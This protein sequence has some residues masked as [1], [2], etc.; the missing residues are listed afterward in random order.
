M[1][2]QPV[3]SK[4]TT[5]AGTTTYGAVNANGTQVQT[6]T[7]TSK[8]SSGQTVAQMTASAPAAAPVTTPVTSNPA[9]SFVAPL[10]QNT[11]AP[12]AP[13]STAVQGGTG[14]ATTPVAQKYGGQPIPAGMTQA[15]YLQSLGAYENYINPDEQ[16]RID[17]AGNEAGQPV[18][19]KIEDAEL[20]KGGAVGGMGGTYSSAIA[21]SYDKQIVSLQT[22]KVN[23]INQAKIAMETAIK[24]GKQ[25]DYDK[26]MGYYNTAIQNDQAQQTLNNTKASTDASIAKT[27]ADT[28]AQTFQNVVSNVAPDIDARL[29]NGEDVSTILADYTAKGYDPTVLNA[30]LVTY[31]QAKQKQDLLNGAQTATILSKTSLGKSVNIPGIGDVTVLGVN[32]T[33]APT[34]LDAGNAGLQEYTPDPTTGVMGWHAIVDP[35]TKQPLTSDAALKLLVSAV[36]N[37]NAD[38]SQLKSIFAGVSGSPLGGISGSFSEAPAGGFRTDRSNNPIAAA[39]ATGGTNDYTKA[40][41]AAGIKW[42]YGDKFA[43]NPNMQTIKIDNSKDAVE[44]SRAILSNSSSIQ[45]WY[46]NHTGKSILT[47][48]GISNN[49]DFKKADKKTQDTVITEIYKNEGGDGSLV[50]QSPTLNTPQTIAQAIMEGKQA[51]ILTG[52]YGQSANVRAALQKKGYDLASAQM[53]WQATQKLLTTMNSSQQ[54]RLRQAV[55]FSYDS[56]DIIDQLNQAWKGGNF[57]LFNSAAITAA[58]S[59]VDNKPLAKPIDITIPNPD[60]SSTT[61]T[62]KDKQGLATL[63]NAQINDLTSELG[64]VYKGGNTS[65]DESLSLA[66]G[67]LKSNWSEETLNSAVQLAR[68]NLQLRKNSIETTQPWTPNGNNNIYTNGSSKFSPDQITTAKKSLQDGEILVMDNTSGQMGA[69]SQDDF[70]PDAY[71]IIQ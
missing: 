68:T 19:Q 12:N 13:V 40:L 6:F 8:N 66:A 7:P 60:G 26:A 52:L 50:G 15:Q 42:S 49:E 20:A 27:Q 54:T 61:T 46:A 41:D 23:A 36:L 14:G 21:A 51:P 57:P 33:G 18:E 38:L 39:V 43:D 63:L 24:T 11:G 29:A 5:A 34:T 3:G 59:G 44:A 69:I 58:S 4:V 2:T 32:N 30:A 48:L 31:Q 53:D 25:A 64:T 70:D 16:A 9:G 47:Q 67:N 17:E 62:I 10:K 1:A 65:T 71:T 22:Q 56:L 28:A 35:N 45:D 55:N 37:P